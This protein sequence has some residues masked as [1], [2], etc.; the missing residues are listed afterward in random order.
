MNWVRMGFNLRK[1]R[2][3]VLRKVVDDTFSVQGEEIPVLSTQP[4]KYLGSHKWYGS[5][6]KDTENLEWVQKDMI[7]CLK[8]IGSSGLL[9]VQE[10]V[11]PVWP[12]SQ[13]KLASNEKVKVHKCW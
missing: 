3:L 7:N 4:V 5:S 13:I 9:E 11:L 12:I 6:L 8:V 2:S 10:L 1:S